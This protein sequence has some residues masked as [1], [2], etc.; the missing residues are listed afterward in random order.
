MSHRLYIAE[1]YACKQLEAA[2]D[3]LSAL[4]VPLQTVVLV[5]WAQ[6]PIDNGGLYYFFGPDFPGL[7]PYDLFV[8]AYRRIGADVAADRLEA[9]T[10]LFPFDAPHLHWDQRSTWLRSHGVALEE[11]DEGICGNAS[12]YPLL[13]AYVDAHSGSFCWD[14]PFPIGPHKPWLP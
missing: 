6:G 14:E 5:M 13:E 4:P 7:P 11:P 1:C 9:A 2:G 8:G 10:R 12:V 3:D